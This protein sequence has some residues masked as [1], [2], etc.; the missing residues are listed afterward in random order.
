VANTAKRAL[1]IWLSVILFGNTV[2]PLAGL[3]TAV[4]FAGV[5]AYNKAREMDGSGSG[6]TYKRGVA[7]GLKEARD[8]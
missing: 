4:V 6:G 8:S 1:L 7:Y 3:G 2:T 5:L